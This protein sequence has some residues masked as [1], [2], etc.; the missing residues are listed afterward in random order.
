MT[1]GIIKWLSITEY[2]HIHFCVNDRFFRIEGTD[3]AVVD[4]VG[5][6][7]FLPDI[8]YHFNSMDPNCV[9]Y[10][11]YNIAPYILNNNNPIKSGD[12]TNCTKDREINGKNISMNIPLFRLTVRLSTLI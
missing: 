8:Q 9:V 11:V 12:T 2:R 7:I 1:T 10:H 4:A 6:N 3:D 5:M